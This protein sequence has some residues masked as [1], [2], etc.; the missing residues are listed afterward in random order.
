MSNPTPCDQIESLFY[1]LNNSDRKDV[2]AKLLSQ[3]VNGASGNDMKEL[4][5]DIS[6]DHRT[7]VSDKFRFMLYFCEVLAN[8]HKAGNFDLRNEYACQTSAKIMNMVNGVVA[9]PRI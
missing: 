2:V 6:H 8:N 5:T 3:F 7:L 4:A 1:K 9:V